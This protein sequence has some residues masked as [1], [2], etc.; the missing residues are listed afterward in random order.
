MSRREKDASQIFAEKCQEFTD[1]LLDLGEFQLDNLIRLNA[2]MLRNCRLFGSGDGDYA[3][4]EVAWYK[5][6]MDEI[7]K[8]MLDAKAA[9]KE[10]L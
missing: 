4:A 7:D 10:E 3:E 1:R 5:E 6:Q 2:E 8:L 9:K